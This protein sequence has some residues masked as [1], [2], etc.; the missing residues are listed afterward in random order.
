AADQAQLDTL[1]NREMYETHKELLTARA[2]YVDQALRMIRI[3]KASS[4]VNAEIDRRRSIAEDKK[5]AYESA[6]NSALPVDTSNASLT[7]DR[8]AVYER[9]YQVATTSGDLYSEYRNW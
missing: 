1:S 5:R 8:N 7:A 2:D 4:I 6:L 9:L 3:E